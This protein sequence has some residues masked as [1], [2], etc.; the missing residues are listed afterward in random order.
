MH[1]FGFVEVNLPVVDSVPGRA[2]VTHRVRVTN[3]KSGTIVHESF[4]I[5]GA[6]L[7]LVES[8]KRCHLDLR[9]Q[10]GVTPEAKSG[11]GRVPSVPEVVSRLLD[12]HIDAASISVL[13]KLELIVEPVKERTK[14]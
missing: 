4:H 6:H 3:V 1:R 12:L 7:G 5:L 11:H 9:L 10:V 14:K 2:L 8:C 13:C